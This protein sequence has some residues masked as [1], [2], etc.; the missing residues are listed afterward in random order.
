MPTFKALDRDHAEDMAGELASVKYKIDSSG[1]LIVESKDD[2]KRRGL[3]S[4]DIAD[5]LGLTFA[6]T[7]L[8]MNINKN[9]AA[10]IRQAN[11][12]RR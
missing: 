10:R 3:R 7:G 8:A 5:A 12:G 11:T 2:M 1:R 9:L 4:P 6:T